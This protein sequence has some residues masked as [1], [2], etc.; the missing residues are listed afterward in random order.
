MRGWAAMALVASV[1]VLAS[2]VGAQIPYRPRPPF[3]ERRNVEFSDQASQEAIARGV[4]YLW[5]VQKHD[6]SWARYMDHDVGPTALAVYALLQSGQDPQSK[7]LKNA[8]KW[9]QENDN[10]FTYDLGLRCCALSLSGKGDPKVRQKLRQDV[11]SLFALYND[12]AYTYGA[13]D[14]EH[15]ASASRYY[16]EEYGWRGDNSNTQYA[17]MGVAAAASFDPKLVAASF[18]GVELK[19]WTRRRT[20]MEDG[21]TK[22]TA[23]ALPCRP[24]RPR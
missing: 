2:S 19:H 4:R 9:L 15:Y 12:G 16:S 3:P 5:S 18:W 24:A 1:G 23:T 7:D 22:R 10:F 20:A 21:P 14:K 17:V 8:I 11:E 13:K 6:G